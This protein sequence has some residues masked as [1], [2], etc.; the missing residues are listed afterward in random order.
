MLRRS[1]HMN[2]RT[3]ARR[4]CL[5]ALLSFGLAFSLV[6]LSDRS[7][8]HGAEVIDQIVAKVNDHIITLTDVSRTI[9]IYMQVMGVDRQRVQTSQGRN[10]LANEVLQHLVDDRLMMD[11]AHRRELAVT[12]AEVDQ[13]LREQRERLGFSAEEYEQQIAAQ[14]LYIE[15][16]REFIHGRLTRLRMMSVDVGTQV[17]ITDEE[18]DQELAARYPDGLVEPYIA[19][20]HILV[21]LASGASP[22]QEDEAV[23]A[24]H[25]HALRLAAG[26]AFETVAAEVNRDAS[27]NTGGR[28]G[29][30]RA[31][32][33]D[34]DYARAAMNLDVGEV[35]GPVRSQFG[36]HLI[37][38][39]AIEYREVDNADELRDR[40]HFELHTAASDRQQRVYLERLRSD[41]FVDIMVTDFGL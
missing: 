2:V 14:G 25:A 13:Y 11:D 36:Y 41:G 37:R 30:F 38:L 17:T 9:P 35:S 34:A 31:D 28:I 29:R 10:V 7:V 16:F 24:I 5:S 32:Q 3:S 26:E 4:S 18:I 15:D 21:Q 27:R 12:Q 33:L 8:A 20:S 22:Q 23:Q 40:V 6:Q 19:T 39:E 1:D